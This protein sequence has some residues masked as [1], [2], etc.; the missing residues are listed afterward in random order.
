MALFCNRF[1]AAE[2]NSHIY[3][4]AKLIIGCRTRFK[5]IITMDRFRTNGNSILL[6]KSRNLTL[7]A[8]S[9][10]RI[11]R[12]LLLASFTS[13][14]AFRVRIGQE[15]VSVT[16]NEALM[17][18]ALLFLCHLFFVAVL[19]MRS[20]GVADGP[21][22]SVTTINHLNAIFA[23]TMEKLLVRSVLCIHH[24]HICH[25]YASHS[26]LCLCANVFPLFPMADLTDR[27]MILRMHSSE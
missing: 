2:W 11:S 22:P 20:S 17:P 9:D 18:F 25:M 7:S 4:E 16:V 14:W 15:V 12:I 26:L 5:N 10:M 27:I 21:R 8:L 24:A 3:T 6:I 19:A 13:G 23:G 1:P